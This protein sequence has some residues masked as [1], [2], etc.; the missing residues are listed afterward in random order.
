SGGLFDVEVVGNVVAVRDGS[1]LIER[2]PECGRVIDGGQCRSHGAVEGEDD[3]R[4]KAIVDD[5]TGT[6]TAILDDELTAAVYG[7]GLEQAREHARDAMDRS[8]VADDIRETIV[9]RAFRVRGS[10]TVDEYGANLTASTFEERDA[11]PAA[12]AKT[13]L[14]EVAA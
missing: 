12:R 7:G 1:G 13:L 4:I 6:V 5:G 10:L 3:L 14:E 11:N 2:C 9:G 8:V